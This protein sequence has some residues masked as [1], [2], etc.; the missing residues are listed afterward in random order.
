MR[1]AAQARRSMSPG[2]M[3]S[4]LS[5]FGGRD[6]SCLAVDRYRRAWRQFRNIVDMIIME[7]AV[8]RT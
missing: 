8:R 3:P 7:L 4:A 5:C 2:G 6:R 1:E